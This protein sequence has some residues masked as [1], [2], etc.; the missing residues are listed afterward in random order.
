M[1]KVNWTKISLKDLKEIHD[2]IAKDSSRYATITINNIY[3]QAQRIKSNSEIG[4][5]VP[6]F[7]DP[8]LRELIIVNYRL[9]YIIKNK[10]Q[11]DILRVYH[12][13]RLLKKDAFK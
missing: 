4:R 7:N 12:S 3:S 1:V 13:A 9:V 6:E 10:F 5:I 2:Y 8:Q 11:I